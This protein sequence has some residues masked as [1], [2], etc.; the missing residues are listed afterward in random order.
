MIRKMS[1]K[2]WARS[3]E[4]GEEERKQTEDKTCEKAGE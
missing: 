3:D 1:E 4:D 2:L